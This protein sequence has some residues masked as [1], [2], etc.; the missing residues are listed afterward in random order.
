MGLTFKTAT[1][2]DSQWY[3]I[4]QITGIAQDG[5]GAVEVKRSLKVTLTAPNSVAPT[6]VNVMTIPWTD[7]QVSTENA[8]IAA[9]SIAITITI[10]FPD[11]Y[12]VNSSTE[13]RIGVNGD[14]TGDAG[15]KCL[16][17]IKVSADD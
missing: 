3:G 16:A 8:Q 7:T 2:A 4:V 14:L 5:G 11:A 10:A 6:D 1:T 17:T 9:E 15:P 13:I 12:T